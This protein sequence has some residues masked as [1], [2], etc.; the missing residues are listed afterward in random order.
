[1]LTFLRKTG[2]NSQHAVAFQYRRM[3]YLFLKVTEG[4]TAKGYHCEMTH[5]EPSPVALFRSDAHC[6][7][8]KRCYSLEDGL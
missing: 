3:I 4:K 2:G 1:M 6:V 8:L 5:R 7:T